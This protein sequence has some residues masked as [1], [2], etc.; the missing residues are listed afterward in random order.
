MFR[1]NSAAPYCIQQHLGLGA[2]LSYGSGC[3]LLEVIYLKSLGFG[4]LA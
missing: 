1:L 3:N 2:L 4:V